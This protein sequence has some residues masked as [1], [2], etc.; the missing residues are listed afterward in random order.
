LDWQARLA[1]L[2]LWCA[3]G[4]GAVMALVMCIPAVLPHM[5]TADGQVQVHTHLYALH[6]PAYVDRTWL[7]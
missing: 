7:D 1:R 5:W 4:S 2:L 6:I 3:A